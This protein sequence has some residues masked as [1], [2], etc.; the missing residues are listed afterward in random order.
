MVRL[1]SDLHQLHITTI[2][3]CAAQYHLS[4]KLALR[5]VIHRVLRLDLTASTP[6]R[7][8]RRSVLRHAPLALGIYPVYPARLIRSDSCGVR[9]TGYNIMS[10]GMNGDCIDR[11]NCNALIFPSLASNAKRAILSAQAICPFVNT[12]GMDEE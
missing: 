2:A 12:G 11:D 4:T 1:G 7:H 10:N 5:R 3:S 9:R 8:E 6:P